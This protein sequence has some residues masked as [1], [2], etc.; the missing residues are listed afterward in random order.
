MEIHR[1]GGSSF[2]ELFKN[3]SQISKMQRK[4]EKKS[5]LSEIIVSELVASNCLYKEEKTCHCQS[6]C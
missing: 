6:M 1:L 2:F 3:L 4:M 5:F